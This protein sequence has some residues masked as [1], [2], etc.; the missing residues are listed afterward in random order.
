MTGQ[1]LEKLSIVT[2][3]EA[4][5]TDHPIGA[6]C[7]LRVGIPGTSP[8]ESVFKGSVPDDHIDEWSVNSHIELTRRSV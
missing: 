4:N 8:R 6:G 2:A 5:T 1:Q 3:H 7:R